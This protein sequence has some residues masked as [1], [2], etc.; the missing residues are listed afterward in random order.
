MKTYCVIVLFIA[1]LWVLAGCGQ[2]PAV[3]PTLAPTSQPDDQP[4][5]TTVPTDALTRAPLTRP[6]FPPTW[7]PTPGSM[8]ETPVETPA[9]QGADTQSAGI[10]MLEVCTSF[11]DDRDRYN[12]EF[13]LGS[14][15][16]VAWLPVEG[17]V[18]YRV[19]LTDE[20]GN[21]LFFAETTETSY[22]FSAD[23]FESGKLYGWNVYPI[24][25]LGQQMCIDV[26]S[27]LYPM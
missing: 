22:T 21:E 15:I 20:N 17:A 1:S 12:P 18:N 27:E 25:I 6:T 2:Q 9:A 10:P 26:G 5:A 23:L 13:P 11:R 4:T 24:D 3:L 19:R 16:T 7:T 8:Q 14:D